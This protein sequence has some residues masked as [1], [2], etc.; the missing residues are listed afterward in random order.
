MDAVKGFLA[1][2]R[3]PLYH[4]DFETYSEAVPPFAGLK[5]YQQIPFQYSLHIQDAPGREPS[6]KEF[7]APEGSDPRR[8][9]AER[10]C[11]EI[12]ADVC[13]LAYNRSFEQTRLRELAEQFEDLAEHLLAIR[14]NI[15]DLMTPFQQHAFYDWRQQGSVSIKYV[16]PAMF[17]DDPELDYHSLEGVQNG[18]QAS[19]TFATLHLQPDEARAKARADL[20]RYC[21]LDTFAMVR[22]LDRLHELSAEPDD[23]AFEILPSAG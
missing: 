21:G 3:Y 16:L 18:G 8:A 19:E 10:L 11:Q 6:H 5:P 22:I 2:V 14:D 20:L 17:P 13:V 23:P 12:P 7:L 1:T 4:L 15:I 9:I